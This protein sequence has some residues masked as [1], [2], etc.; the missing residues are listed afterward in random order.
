VGRPL[1]LRVFLSSPGDVFEE[2]RIALNLLEH[3]PRQPLLSGKVSLEVVAWDDPDAPTPL[4]AT[5]P[6]QDSVNRYKPRSSQCDLTIVILWGRLGTP[7]PEQ[8]REPHQLRYAS[9][10]AWEYEDA[11]SAKKEVW[12]YCRT[13]KPRLEIDDPELEAKRANYNAVQKFRR[14]FRNADGSLK[15]GVNEYQSLDQFAELL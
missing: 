1:H 7:L 15:G 12:V 14:G 5:E 9:G 3:F 8:Q 13:E 11:V 10:T 6:P 4:A 2:R